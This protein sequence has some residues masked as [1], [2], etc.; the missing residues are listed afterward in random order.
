MAD[1]R[2]SGAL[3]AVLHLLDRQVV[4]VD[5]LMVCKVDDVE[6]TE[7]EGGGLAVTAL[8]AG[9]SALV[10]RYA[11]GRLS[12]ALHEFWRRLWPERADRDDPYR[13][14]LALV[15]RLGSGVELSVRREGV[16]LRQGQAA[17]RLN[18]LLQLPVRT[19]DDSDAGRVLDVRLT[20]DHDGDGMLRVTGLVVGRGRPGSYLGYDR[21]GDMG[22]WLVNRVV[23]ALHRHSGFV[24]MEEVARVDWEEGVIRLRGTELRGL[25]P[26]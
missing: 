3:D 1:D 11:D 14:D 22:P 24:E 9:P 10:P 16:L 5:G 13:I 20:R 7:L 23:R 19:S 18:D 26:A 25:R 6:L 2:L 15:H 21:R 17:R 12:R 4:D 8:L